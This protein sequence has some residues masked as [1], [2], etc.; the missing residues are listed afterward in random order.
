MWRLQSCQPDRRRQAI[1]SL[2]QSIA[3]TFLCQTQRHSDTLIERYPRAGPGEIYLLEEV[4][5]LGAMLAQGC[6]IEDYIDGDL[7]ALWAQDA[8]FLRLAADAHLASSFI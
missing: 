7:H 5:I 1:K 3:L 4:S 2:S 8:S 6:L